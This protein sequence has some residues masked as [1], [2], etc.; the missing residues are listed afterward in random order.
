MIMGRMLE[1]GLID[2][3]AAISGMGVTASDVGRKYC[4]WVDGI[5]LKELY[6]MVSKESKKA[7][8]TIKKGMN[9]IY[10][11]KLDMS[12]P[13]QMRTMAATMPRIRPM[14]FSL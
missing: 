11:I 4:D 2:L 12:H 10:G 3:D 14:L 6:G 7:E 1:D 9:P 13:L 5:D 8:T